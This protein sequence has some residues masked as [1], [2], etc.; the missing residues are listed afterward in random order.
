MN[1]LGKLF[2][3]LWRGNL[4]DPNTQLSDPD[5]WLWDAWGAQKST[6]GVRVNR[7]KALTYAAWWRGVNLIS[8]DV[9][10][11]PLV[12][13][14]RT[15]DGREKA[16]EHPAFS[17]LRYKSND[18]ATSFTV[19]QTLQAHALSTG[20]GYAHIDR[21]GAGRPR[22]L[23]VLDPDKTYP[24]RENRVLW[25]MTEVNGEWRKLDPTNV[26][27]VRG[28][29][30]DGLVGYSVVSVAR[31]SLGLGLAA[32]EHGSRFFSSGTSKRVV[33]EVPQEISEDA[34]KNI[35]RSY[36]KVA[37]GLENSHKAIILQQGAKAN[38]TI[39]MSAKDAQL[40]ETRT[41]ELRDVAN[42][43]GVPPHKLGDTTRTAFASLE[44]E[45]QSYL[46]EALDAWLVIW[47]MECRDKLLT[48]QEKRDD[49][50]IV[51]FNRNALVR[52]DFK[53]RMEAYFK[54]CGGPFLLVNEV[55]AKENQNKVDGG[56]KL[57]DPLNM[58][59]AAGE[60][61]GEGD[62]D[63]PQPARDPPPQD[64]DEDEE[65]DQDRRLRSA[66]EAVLGDA[67]RRMRRRLAVHCRKAARR[68]EGFGDWLEG[69]RSDHDQV[70]AD[71]LRPAA[72]CIAIQDGTDLDAAVDAHRDGLFDELHQVA[73]EIYS[74]VPRSEF[75]ERIEQAMEQWENE[76][77][78]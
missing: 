41:F 76:N 4:E 59:D 19:R 51:E 7:D 49:S 28:L 77:A 20:N 25:Y 18:E 12:V 35:L 36:N 6:S 55:R 54:A 67:L 38:A 78:H 1:L 60:D 31:E 2:S 46:D 53:T 8:R 22:Q 14:K 3:W 63:D 62:G 37:T 69:F 15:D 64:G 27:H 33:I 26:L 17:L 42:W 11:L 74:T 23:I 13:Y 16:P 24:R 50:H 44:Q 43:F 47:E 75:L 21:D 61:E 70:V 39:G 9:G 66:H 72:G 32:R 58:T 34:E 5:A 56:D 40:L 52:A 29:G 45:N 71:A 10:K 73:D 57:R 48:E 68:P 30:F 65:E